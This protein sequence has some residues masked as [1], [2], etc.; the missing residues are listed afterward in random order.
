[1]DHKIILFYRYVLIDNIEEMISYLHNLCSELKILGRILVANE[2]INGTLASDCNN[3]DQFMETI[4]KDPKFKNID[5]KISLGRGNLPF[6]DLHVKQVKEL[7][8][9]GEAKSIIDGSIAFDEDT[10]GGL[11]GTGIHLSPSAFHEAILNNDGILLDIRNDYEYSIG[12]FNNAINLSTNTFAE[13]W[14][15]LDKVVEQQASSLSEKKTKN[16]YMYCTG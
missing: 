11:A 9:C 10:Y 5:W 16:I 12:H 8:G 3:I 14:R 2:G 15:A 7:I 1:M 6:N 4:A 13:T